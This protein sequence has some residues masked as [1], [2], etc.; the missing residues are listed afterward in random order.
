MTFLL[1]VQNKLWCAVNESCHPSSQVSKHAWTARA[2][3]FDIGT[4]KDDGPGAAE[5][6]RQLKSGIHHR[7][8]DVACDSRSGLWG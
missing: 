4:K 5:S 8:P 1:A 6:P 3:R 2:A 7:F